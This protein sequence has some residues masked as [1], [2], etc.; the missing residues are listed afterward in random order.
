MELSTFFSMKRSKNVSNTHTHT[1]MWLSPKIFEWSHIMNWLSFVCHSDF[2]PTTINTFN[3]NLK[4]S[5][6]YI[7]NFRLPFV[8]HVCFCWKISQ[9][10]SLSPPVVRAYVCMFFPFNVQVKQKLA[11]VQMDTLVTLIILCKFEDDYFSVAAFKIWEREIKELLSSQSKIWTVPDDVKK[12]W[13]FSWDF[14]HKPIKTRVK[15]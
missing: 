8:G 5:T 15:V 7:V 10:H 3:T 4:L 11:G 14:V 2:N 13:T 1:H 12:I 6:L 9:I